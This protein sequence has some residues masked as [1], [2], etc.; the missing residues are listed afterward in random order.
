[1]VAKSRRLGARQQSTT[2]I[3]SEEPFSFTYGSRM[4]AVVGKYKW[5]NVR[6]DSKST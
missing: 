1:L 4:I 2:A 5:L 6:Q 3:S